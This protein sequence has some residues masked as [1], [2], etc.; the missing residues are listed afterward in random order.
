MLKNSIEQNVYFFLDPECVKGSLESESLFSYYVRCC[1]KQP[2]FFCINTIISH[3]PLFT[4]KWLKW[5]I[6]CVHCFFSLSEF[7]SS[8][9]IDLCYQSGFC[10]SVL[11]TFFRWNITT[12]SLK[13]F[14][15]C[16]PFLHRSSSCPVLARDLPYLSMLPSWTLA[17]FPCWLM[18]QGLCSCQTTP[19]FQPDSLLKWWVL[20]L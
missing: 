4:L 11:F 1:V 17:A 8:L 20:M 19:Q 5:I 13:I 3:Q 10:H 16:N 15:M 14:D 12:F 7:I 2:P 6:S 9:L 18:S